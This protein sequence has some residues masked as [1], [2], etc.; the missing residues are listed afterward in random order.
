MLAASNLA[1]V[2]P[3]IAGTVTLLVGLV[4][5][6]I[7]QKYVSRV[8]DFF[9]FL[10]LIFFWLF[11]AFR[12][13]FVSLPSLSARTLYLTNISFYRADTLFAL[14]R[15]WV[16][17]R[18]KRYL[19]LYVSLLSYLIL[20]NLIFYTRSNMTAAMLHL[21]PMQLRQLQHLLLSNK[22]Q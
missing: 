13:T 10:F 18:E 22:V 4:L 1:L 7:G 3:F 16:R 15:R 9:I 6:G 17:E 14:T 11:L 8:F 2:A 12:L 21:Q 20:R 19:S 5:R